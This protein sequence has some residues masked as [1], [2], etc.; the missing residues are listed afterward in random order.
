[1]YGATLKQITSFYLFILI[2]PFK[3]FIALLDIALILKY[4]NNMIF[5]PREHKCQDIV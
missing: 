5:A 1:M 2:N 3:L 4:R